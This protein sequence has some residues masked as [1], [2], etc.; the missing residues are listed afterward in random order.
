MIYVIQAGE[1]GP[2]KIGTAADPGRRLQSLQV[3]NPDRLRLIAVWP[4]DSAVEDAIHAELNR[5]HRSGEWFGPAKAVLLALDQFFGG[6]NYERLGGRAYALLSRS[7]GEVATSRCPFCGVCHVHGAEDGHHVAHCSGPYR[8][9]IEARD[10]T[11]L[12]QADGYIVRTA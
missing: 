3:G 1:H 9:V 2:I 7:P 12:C 11:V 4:G 10:G 6:V 5:W 8:P